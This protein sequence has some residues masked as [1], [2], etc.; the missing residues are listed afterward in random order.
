M[1]FKYLCFQVGKILKLKPKLRL[2]PKKT[3]KQL[4]CPKTAP[5]HPTGWFEGST[6]DSHWRPI[7]YPAMGFL[8]G[9]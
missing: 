2:H 8:L 4:T 1:V 3:T 7:G 9:W 6:E 5:Q